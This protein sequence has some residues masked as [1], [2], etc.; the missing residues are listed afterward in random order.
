MSLLR[1]APLSRA[2]LSRGYAASKG[3]ICDIP[4]VKKWDKLAMEE[5]E[6]LRREWRQKMK[7]NDWK[8]FSLEEKQACKR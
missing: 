4:F 6:V 5:K 2:A 8:S 1:A 7:E 3:S